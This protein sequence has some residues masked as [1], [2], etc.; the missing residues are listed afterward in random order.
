MG[1]S[2]FLFHLLAFVLVLGAVSVT[3]EYLLNVDN[4]KFSLMKFNIFA[5][6]IFVTFSSFQGL[7]FGTPLG[8]SLL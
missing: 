7:I 8:V 5:V 3:G 1:R 2:R 4:S 6:L